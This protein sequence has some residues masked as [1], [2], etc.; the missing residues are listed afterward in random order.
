[1][2]DTPPQLEWALEKPKR[3][4][5]YFYIGPVY[6]NEFK[7]CKPLSGLHLYPLT[8]A[9]VGAWVQEIPVSST[10]WETGTIMVEFLCS[11]V[12][13]KLREIP[14]DA[15]W[16]GPITPPQNENYPCKNTDTPHTAEIQNS[17]YWGRAIKAFNM[18]SEL[19]D[20]DG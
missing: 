14:D 8:V 3:A 12:T 16:A 9:R 10:N 6:A 2:T 11:T 15:L 4:G 13:R 19:I 20:K 7:R 5:F 18:L 1:M 17:V